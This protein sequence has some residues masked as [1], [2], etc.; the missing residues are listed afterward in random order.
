MTKLT[1][2]ERAQREREAQFAD[3]AL[4]EVAQFARLREAF[5]D[6][7]DAEITAQLDEMLIALDATSADIAQYRLPGTV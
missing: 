3:E 7:T 6:L 1:A 4:Q 2:E 5:P